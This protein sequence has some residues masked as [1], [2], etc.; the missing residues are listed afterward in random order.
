VADALAQAVTASPVPADGGSIVA[1]QSAFFELL[2]AA[3][4][5]AAVAS[6]VRRGGDIVLNATV[7][8]ALLGAVHGRNA[9]PAQWRSMILSCRPH[10]LRARRPRRRIYWPTDVLELAERLLLAGTARAGA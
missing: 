6:T 4:V 1:L 10:P 3:D 5:E 8:G 9:V 7:A 2:H